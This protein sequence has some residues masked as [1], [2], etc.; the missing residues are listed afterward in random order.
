MDD[1]LRELCTDADNSAPAWEAASDVSVRGSRDHRRNVV[2][3]TLPTLDA[4]RPP[5][6]R[7]ESTHP[8]TE[9]HARSLDGEART[10]RRA[11]R[12][13]ESNDIAGSI[14]RREMQR[15]VI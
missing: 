14:T 8:M 13:R 1:A 7:V 9:N 2:E 3:R 12:Q 10:E 11:V 5:R 6:P 4:V 15:S